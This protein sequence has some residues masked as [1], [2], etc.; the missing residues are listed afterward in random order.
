MEV[1]KYVGGVLGPPFLNLR[2]RVA[3]YGA[4]LPFSFAG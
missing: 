1:Y 3:I 4:K 2:L